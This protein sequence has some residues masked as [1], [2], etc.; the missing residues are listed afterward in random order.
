MLDRLQATRA[1][2]ARRLRPAAGR[3]C[4]SAAARWCRSP[5]PGASTAAQE[6]ADTWTLDARGRRT[7]P[8]GVR[9]RAVQH[10]LRLRRRRGAGLDQRRPAHAG[11]AASTRSAA[12]GRSRGDLRSPSGRHARRARAVRQRLA[13]RGG[14]GRR[15]GRRRRRARAWRRFAPRCS[16]LLARPRALQPRSSCSTAA[17]SPTQLL[18]RESSSAGPRPG[19][20]SRVTVDSAPTTAWRGEVGV[21][22]KLHRRAPR[23]IPRTRS[24]W[25]AGPE[26][27]MRFAARACE[28][29]RPGRAHLR[30]DG[31]QHEVRASATA[32][33]ASSDPTFVCRDGPGVP[34]L[35]DRSLCS[36]IREL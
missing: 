33:A 14:G 13:A 31:A 19:S 16:R 15:R 24:R 9:A 5:S 10:G 18:Y 20:T 12:S 4:L 28:R 22:T 35:G 6:T 30:L 23:S 29:G 26:V 1:A 7:R 2:A 11:A 8:T 17:A 25:S 34:A 32:A 21:V 36:T 27:M 3:A